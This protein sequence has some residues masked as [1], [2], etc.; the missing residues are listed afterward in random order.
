MLDCWISG[1]SL[2]KSCGLNRLKGL[3]PIEMTPF[4]QIYIYECENRRIMNQ[5]IALPIFE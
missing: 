5:Q 1:L 3:S 4:S 2:G